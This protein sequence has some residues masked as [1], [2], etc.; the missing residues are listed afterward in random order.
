MKYREC[1]IILVLNCLCAAVFGQLEPVGK[2]IHSTTTKINLVEKQLVK[3]KDSLVFLQGGSAFQTGFLLD[4]IIMKWGELVI[5][6][7][8]P[9]RMVMAPIVRR[10]ETGIIFNYN[11]YLRLTLDGNSLFP[12]KQYLLGD[13]GEG[14]SSK[15]EV[16]SHKIIWTHILQ[17]YV[18]LQGELKVELEV[19]EFTNVLSWLNLNCQ[20]IPIFETQQRLP[21]YIAGGVGAGLILTGAILGSRDSNGDPDNDIYS[22]LMISGT[23]ILAAD[24]VFYFKRKRR[25]N[26][27]LE[28][29]KQYCGS[30]YLSICPIF[31][32]STGKNSAPSAGL[33]LALVF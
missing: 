12:E 15:K 24:A 13:I 6:Y 22:I 7:H 9:E 20:E 21:Y 8:L 27:D 31:E 29:Y 26:L 28:I 2:S 3:L 1:L 19:E 11:V 17:D 4:S 5:Y 30:N 33:R 16:N 14:V 10:R 18:N 32:K 25:Y 23:G